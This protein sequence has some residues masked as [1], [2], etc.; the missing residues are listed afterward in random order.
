M[1]AH[2]PWPHIATLGDVVRHNAM[3][4]SD[5]VAFHDASGTTTFADFAARVAALQAAFATL[6]LH[7]GDRVAFLSRN[8]TEYVEIYAASDGGVIAVPLNWRISA[9]EIAQLLH[10]CRPSL[11]IVEAEYIDRIEAIRDAL[12]HITHQA[13]LGA[14]R[15]GWTPYEDLIRLGTA[16][17]EQAAVSAAADDPACI[18]YTSGTT[19]LPKGAILT[20][21]ALLGNCRDAIEELIVL[22]PEDVTLSV[23]P[24]FHVGGMWYHLFPSFAAG[25]TT[26]IQ[27]SFVPDAVLDA[28][29]R[30]GVTNVHLVPTMISDLVD[31]PGVT[32]LSKTLRTVFYA[33]SPMP[34]GLLRRA[35]VR[36]A[37]C[38]FLQ[39]YGST[40][41]GQIAWLSPHDHARIMTDSA[42]EELLSSC[43]R[44][45]RGV[46]IR[47]LDA[48][49]TQVPTGEVGELTVRSAN[50][51][52]G[53]W[54]NAVATAAVIQNGWL[55]T[56]DLARRDEHG[57]YFIT[58]RK[59]D[60]II[61]GGENVYPF[62][63]EQ[64]LYEMPQIAEATVIGLP[65]PRWVER[66]VACVVLRPSATL[67][68]AQVLAYAR[69]R[70]TEYKRPKQVILM[71]TL[72]KNGVG[73]ILRKELRTRF[74]AA[75]GA[76]K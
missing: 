74:G 50:T 65:D 40:E 27:P 75:I 9:N 33:A 66:V 23:M 17:P 34:A 61:S 47:L 56:G 20:H 70:L 73:K 19:G 12:P 13:I 64:I 49:G 11:L 62:E 68:E 31:R 43:G 44:P 71:D 45:V 69:T 36:F 41:G 25:A 59:N 4:H 15:P 2:I 8:R 51:M 37:G 7:Q 57:Y 21:H 18:I 14:A 60:M 48:N 76:L 39:E 42:A 32:D 30:Y 22:T 1:T 72:P 63:V 28:I 52:K 26:I 54:N 38:G 24:L 67:T 16:N 10:D 3:R 53:Y 29:Q 55:R 6:G 46:E 5:R 35:M 58:D